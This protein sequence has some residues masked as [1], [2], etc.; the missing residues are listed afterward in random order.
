MGPTSSLCVKQLQNISQDVFVEKSELWTLW[1]WCLSPAQT[2][3]YGQ[4]AN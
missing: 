1:G 2:L 3:S 4:I